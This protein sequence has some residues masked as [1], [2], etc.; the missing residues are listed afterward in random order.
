[1]YFRIFLR[2]W[3]IMVLTVASG[4]GMTLFISF[5]ETPMYRTS[6]KLIVGPNPSYM[7]D[8][9]DLIRSIETL[10]SGGVYM[11]T[12]AEI[13]NSYQIHEEACIALSL[14]P[15]ETLSVYKF[16]AVVLPGTSALELFVSGPDPQTT[17]L[18]ADEVRKRAKEYMD[19][20]YPVYI[21]D[22]FDPAR[23]PDN[24]ISPNPKRDATL[25]TALA[26]IIGAG[27]IILYA[28][29]LRSRNRSHQNKGE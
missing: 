1:M 7:Q 9:G 23:V 5:R 24:P 6:I 4:I 11:P 25:A 27:L 8:E 15:K 13:L 20:L 16:V 29:W 2:G 14:P 19:K 12:Y 22:T 17:V 3:W 10:E 18:L 21:L 28:Q 26:I